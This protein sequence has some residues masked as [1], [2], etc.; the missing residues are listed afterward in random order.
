MSRLPPIA[1]SGGSHVPPSGPTLG[2]RDSVPFEVGGVLGRG[3]MGE[4][5]TAYDPRLGRD[6]AIKTVTPGDAASAARL[7]REA[8]LTARLEHPGIMPVYEAGRGDDG[9]PWYAMRLFTGRTLAEAIAATPALSDRLRLVRHV[10]DAAQAI[11]YANGQGILHRDLKPA[12]IITGAFGETIV[13]DWGLACTKDEAANSEAGAGTPGYMSPEQVAGGPLDSRTDVYGLGGILSEVLSA[14]PPDDQGA[15]SLHDIN[16]AP[17]ELVAIAER[18][19]QRDVEDRYPSTIALADDLLAWFEGR[20]VG[21]HEY[22]AAEL[23]RRL[24]QAWRVPIGV[25]AAGLAAV[26]LAAAVGWS[27]TSEQRQHAE[28]AERAA[29]RARADEKQAF[30][31]VLRIQ[32]KLAAE[33]GLAMEAEVLAA[34]ALLRDDNADARGVLSAAFGRPRWSRT[35]TRPLPACRRAVLSARGDALACVTDDEARVVEIASGGTTRTTKGQWARANFTS[36]STHVLLTDALSKSWAWRTDGAP[37]P[38]DVA[39]SAWGAYPRSPIT[40]TAI[41]QGIMSEVRVSFDTGTATSTRGCAP[42]AAVQA[43]ALDASNALLTACNDGRIVRIAEGRPAVTLFVL[44]EADG[45]PSLLQPISDERLFVG[46]TGGRAILLDA[47]GAV[48]ARQRLGN[49]SVFAAEANGDRVAV[50]MTGGDVA[51]WDVPSNTTQMRFHGALLEAAWRPDG[52]IRLLSTTVD[53]R[54]APTEPRPH[55][56]TLDAGLSALAFSPDGHLLAVAAGNGFLTLLEPATGRIVHRLRA[57]EAVAKDAAFSPDGRF[58][59]VASAGSR[60]VIYDV[61][62]GNSSSAIDGFGA[63]RAGWFAQAGP[64]AAPYGPG[65]WRIPR[66]TEEKGVYSREPGFQDME[67]NLAGTHAAALAGDDTLWVGNDGPTVTWRR[68]GS[69]APSTGI[70]V[71]GDAVFAATNTA[72]MRFSSE[73]EVTWK[74]SIPGGVTDLAAS[75]D[76]RW[77]ALGTLDGT[78]LVYQVGGS[79]P[80]ARMAAH[81]ARVSAVAFSADSQWLAS[82][83]WDNDVRMWSVTAFEA[84]AST[85]AG[86][87]EA[88]WGATLDE[89]LATI[90]VTGGK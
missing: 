90:L 8:V 63:R 15:A 81:H 73:D 51:V 87:V 2:A 54:L 24:I 59:L 58:L 89:V 1:H 9:R 34:N 12:N 77:V 11:A 47:S 70:T 56:Y 82:G 72:L 4:V 71:A 20:R 45:M 28:L 86:V 64:I 16:G 67:V 40:N 37:V 7:A 5:R 53:D 14:H 38:L 32:S 21:A 23:F 39:A 25:G 74:V 76:G 42:A 60:Q 31:A 61:G 62:S 3:G 17:P 29:I 57:E 41:M 75:P 49:G 10:L 85:T 19:L 26:G 48:I 35:A 78:L 22:S 50:S 65:M 36:D 84:D 33:S 18:A 80:V 69:V 44:A 68:I 13:A 55:R 52:Q 46:T 27:A 43:V 66:S 79:A 6:V 83:G 30:A 88:N